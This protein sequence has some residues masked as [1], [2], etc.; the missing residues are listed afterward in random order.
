MKITIGTVIKFKDTGNVFV[1][2]AVDIRTDLFNKS[3]YG[4]ASLS[5]VIIEDH[6]TRVFESDDVMLH[7]FEAT[8]SALF[9]ALKV[10]EI[11]IHSPS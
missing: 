7:A 9:A 6:K 5:P 8:D 4:V 11:E 10:N 3:A 2:T 1:V